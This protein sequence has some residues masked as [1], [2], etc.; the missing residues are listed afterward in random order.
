M[1]KYVAAMLV[2]VFSLNF[3]GTYATEIFSGGADGYGAQIN[4]L[5]GATINQNTGTNAQIG[6][7]GNGNVIKWDHLNVG[8]GNKLDFNF[9][10]QGQVILNKVNGGVSKF[11]GQLSTSGE[12]G[13]LL[14][15]N[16]NGMI[17]LNGAVIN[18]DA[19][20]ATFTT[21]D[22]TW[23]GQK[24]GAIT[25]KNTGSNMGIEI[26]EPGGS[27]VPVF[28]VNNDLNIIAPGVEVQ[29]ADLFA[30][31]TV[32]LISAD[33]VNFVAEKNT[34][35]ETIT[36]TKIRQT[37]VMYARL[38]GNGQINY[39]SGNNGGLKLANIKTNAT[40]AVQ[41]GDKLYL[42][43]EDGGNSDLNDLDNIAKGNPDDIPGGVP[44]TKLVDDLDDIPGDTPPP[45]TGG[46]DPG[47]DSGG[48]DKKRPHL[49]N[50]HT[51][52][53][54]INHN[55]RTAHNNRPNNDR[56]HSNR[57]HGDKPQPDDTDLGT[58][59]GTDPGDNPDPDDGGTNPGDGGSGSTD[60]ERPHGNRP[61]NG[62]PN[63][64]TPHNN[65]PQSSRPHGNTHNNR[66]QHDRPHGGKPQNDTPQGVAPF[67]DDS[68]DQGGDNN[69][70][71]DTGN[72]TIADVSDTG[73]TTNNGA[74]NVRMGN[75]QVGAADEEYKVAEDI[76]T[77]F[78]KKFNPRSFAAGDDEITK[79][80]QDVISNTVKTS[81]GSIII[82][83][84]FRVH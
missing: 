73:D 27:K 4:D 56:P 53:E 66:P 39:V 46:T 77:V 67:G 23:D 29:K 22:V 47:N 83:K 31:G 58:G 48:K 6:A 40:I 74:T 50:T 78:R 7:T 42:Y 11:A 79:K 51:R 62:R 16:P 72:N 17:F 68:Q 71:N 61:Q 69:T 34:V 65:R 9:T 52:N 76:D 84:A 26:G 75:S 49:N 12:N 59:G 5:G 33:G 41:D 44:D 63:I 64:N 13:H 45:D 18:V 8:A 1:K 30:G 14:I 25:T 80:K 60:K 54:R 21:H 24:N 37:D 3:S 35:P 28:R 19:G 20:S 57:P 81:S 55:N 32:R 38:T 15:S 70:G 36:K 10:Q 43:S 2:T 82:N